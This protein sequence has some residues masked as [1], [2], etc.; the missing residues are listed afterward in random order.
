VA[1]STL[2]RADV[3]TIIG[4]SC[5]RSLQNNQFALEFDLGDESHYDGWNEDLKLLIARIL[6][7]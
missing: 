5:F 6:K 4:E 7:I 1:N 2:F 3:A